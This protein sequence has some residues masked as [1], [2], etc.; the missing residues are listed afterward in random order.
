ML[1]VSGGVTPPVIPCLHGLY[2]RKFH[3]E[4]DIHTI[5]M[6]EQLLS[7][8]SDNHQ[9]LGELLMGFLHY[10]STFEYNLYAISVRLGARIPIDECRLARSQKN[11]P[12]QWKY[13]CIE[14]PFD[15]TNTARSVYD[16]EVF[17]QVKS[18]FVS[19]YNKLNETRDLMGIFK[20]NDAEAI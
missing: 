10:Y 12:H 8:K 6:H 3:T 18:V 14:E 16:P 5:D 13:L 19:S 11:D 20:L 7:F 9:T 15:L 1:A 4:S 2:P 17:Q